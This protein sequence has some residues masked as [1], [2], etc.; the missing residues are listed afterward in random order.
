MLDRGLRRRF[1]PLVEREAREAAEQPVEPGARLDLRDLPTF[2]IDP[3]T[4]RD[5]DDAIS[6]EVLDDGAVRVWVHIADVSHY[7][8]PGSHVDREAFRRATSV[9][10][11]GA[12]EPMLPEALSNQACSLVPHQDRYAVTVEME[13]EGAKVRRTAFHRSV[14]RSDERLDLPAGGPDLRGRGARRGAVGGAAGRCPARRRRARAG[15]RVARRARGRL[16]RAGVRVLARGPRDR[17][18]VERADRVAPA[19]RAPDDR[20][21]RGGR[22]A[23]G[24][25]QA[26]HALPRPRAARAGAGRAPARPAR[27]A[28]RPD[29]A[30]CPSG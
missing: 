7:V 30:G 5:F 23:A 29:A 28:R 4:A 20:G 3:P 10:V 22:D 24:G 21:Q 11:P 8:R 17:A 13:L 27:L 6:A 14:I 9:Y 1:E 19:D 26:P 18:D 16:A 12:V 25:A 2:T 15:A